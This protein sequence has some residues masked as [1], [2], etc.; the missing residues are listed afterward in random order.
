MPV[1]INDAAA[2]C[3]EPVDGSWRREVVQESVG[4]AIGC[5]R[6][7]AGEF[8]PARRQVSFDRR[9]RGWDAINRRQLLCVAVQQVANEQEEDEWD[10]ED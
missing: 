6:P 3:G 8:I 5:G 2:G 4:E 10:S 1:R 7:E 9:A